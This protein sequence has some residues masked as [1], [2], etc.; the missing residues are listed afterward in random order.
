MN[1]VQSKSG[2]CT[3]T[4]LDLFSVPPTHVSL[5]KRL[6]V[7]H[8]L[9]SSVLDA[10]PITFLCPGTE[11]YMDLSKTIL[12]VCAK[13]TKAN[14]NDLDADEKVG[15]V[16]NFLHSLFKQVDAF[17]KEKTSD[18]SDRNVCLSCLLGNALKLWFCGKTVSIDGRY[19]LQGTA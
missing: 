10:R 15:I 5:E 18:P 17:L 19:V 14:R 3:K 7:D 11:D 9:V 2:E 8:Q 16:D 13:V 12:V 1:F 6:W 4:E